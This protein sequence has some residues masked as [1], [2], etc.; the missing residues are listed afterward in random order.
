MLLR[1]GYNQ[2]SGTEKDKNVAQNGIQLNS[3]DGEG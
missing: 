3:R 2:T 1:M